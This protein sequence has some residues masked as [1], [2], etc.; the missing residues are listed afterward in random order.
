MF[1]SIGKEIHEILGHRE[2]E[3]C[4]SVKKRSLFWPEDEVEMRL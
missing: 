4:L 3:A 2:A 1:E